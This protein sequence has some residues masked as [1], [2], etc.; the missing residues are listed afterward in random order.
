MVFRRSTMLWVRASVLTSVLRSMTNF[1]GCAFVPNLAEILPQ[2]HCQNKG[3]TIVLW[4]WEFGNWER[5]ERNIYSGAGRDPENALFIHLALEFLHRFW[6]YHFPRNT[7]S[8][9]SSRK[10]SA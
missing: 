8:M 4:N 9:S 2:N 7:F 1:M 6:L 5:W 10:Y 3:E